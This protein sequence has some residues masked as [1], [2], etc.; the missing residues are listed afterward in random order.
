LRVDALDADDAG[1]EVEV[2]S[3]E[4]EQ[5]LRAEAGPDEHGRDLA[6]A[7]VDLLADRLDL[8]PGL[9]WVDLP[10][11]DGRADVPDPACGVR[12]DQPHPDGIL[13]H[14]TEGPKDVV[15]RAGG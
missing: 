11:V 7:R 2:A 15:R 10:S 13:E 3:L 6:V 9:E 12:F 4:R 8:G 1:L 5:L 14:L